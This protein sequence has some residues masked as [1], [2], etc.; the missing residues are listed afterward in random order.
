[1]ALLFYGLMMAAAV[2]TFAWY[3]T[4]ES[5][6]AQRRKRTYGRLAVGAWALVLLLAIRL[7]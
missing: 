7:F 1:M 4:A 3:G 5:Q 6:R 2:F